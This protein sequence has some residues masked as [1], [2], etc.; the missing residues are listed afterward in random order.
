M[1][2]PKE[3]ITEFVAA[4][5]REFDYYQAAARLCSQRCEALLTARGVRAIVSHR[6]KRPQK[7]LAKLIERDVDRSYASSQQIREDIADLAG[8]RIALYFPGDRERV[9]AILRDS[10]SIVKETRFPDDT[11]NKRPAKRFSG[12]YA[13]HYRSYLQDESLDESQK[14][15]AT[16]MIEIQVGSVLMHAWAEVEHDL[17]YK[18]ES[19]EISEDEE[20]ILD[21]INGLV[22]TGEVALERLQRAVERRLAEKHVKFDNQYDLAAY[23]HRWL[24]SSSRSSEYSIGRLDVLWALLR[25]ANLNSAAELE[26]Q[27]GDPATLNVDAPISDQISDIILGKN[28]HLYRFYSMLQSKTVLTSMYDQSRPIETARSEAIGR[29]LSSWIMLEL[30]CSLSGNRYA[31][32]PNNDPSPNRPSF[33]PSDISAWARQIELSPRAQVII[34]QVKQ[35]RNQ[36]VHGVEMPSRD[37]LQE[38][39]S[40]LDNVLSEVASNSDESVRSAY[41]AA[42]QRMAGL[43]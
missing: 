22:I 34:R 38:A 13:D 15:Y 9:R 6:A 23:L 8:A 39:T 36:L 20:A 21:E 37:F 10:F 14:Q 35:V 17:I 5:T 19:G 32:S 42:R 25:E 31:N 28:P 26:G 30:T 7:L 33:R 1:K 43:D 41:E 27:V 18:P 16:A 3:V 11:K 12:Y 4:Y 24:S 40:E 2:V 29:F